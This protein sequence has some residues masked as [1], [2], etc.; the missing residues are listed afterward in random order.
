MQSVSRKKLLTLGLSSALA[1]AASNLV[2]PFEGLVKKSYVD[3]VGIITACYGH[4]G[5]ELKLGQTFSD[6]ECLEHLARD[7]DSHN[8]E[9]MASIKVPVN[10]NHQAAFLSFT[11]N[12]GVGNFRK[13]TL[14]KKLNDG[15]YQ[16]ACQELTK[17]VYAG[18]RKM[19][20]LVNRRQ[21]EYKL[22]MSNL[23]P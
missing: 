16:E 7:L 18:G 6:N 11:Y 2:I 21:A 10:V 1:L 17:W 4:T 19:Q 22:C 12:V 8:R 3:P 23:N 14:L 20:G 5:K 9:M 15:M 13:S